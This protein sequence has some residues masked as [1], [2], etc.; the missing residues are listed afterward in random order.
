[1][2]RVC[3]FVSTRFFSYLIMVCECWRRPTGDVQ[4]YFSLPSPNLVSPH[5]TATSSQNAIHHSLAQLS[6][7]NLQSPLFNIYTSPLIVFPEALLR[8]FGQS[9]HFFLAWGVN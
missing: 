9:F 8:L 1:M 7:I 5:A 2:F 4:V 6:S 3:Y